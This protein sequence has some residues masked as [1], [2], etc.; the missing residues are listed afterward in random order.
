MKTRISIIVLAL[1]ALAAFAAPASA[2]GPRPRSGGGVS[3]GGNTTVE[4]GSSS[5]G[6][7]WFG[8]NVTVRSGGA[9]DGDSV[10]FGGN[11][12]VEPGGR[13]QGDIVLLGGKMD[14]AGEANGDLVLVG[15][16]VRLK[17]T[18]VVK[19]NIRLQGGNLQRDDG[20]IVQGDVNRN[21]GPFIPIPS[22]PPLP[23]GTVRSNFG[24]FDFFGGIIHAM[25]LA[26]LG[27]L[28]VVFFPSP[29]QRVSETVQHSFAPSF[30]VGCLTFVIAPVLLL[31]LTITIIGIPIVALLAIV[32]AAAWYLGWITLGYLAGERILQA[33]KVREIAPVLAAVVGVVLLAFVGAVPVLGGM[34]SLLI[35]TLGLGAVILTRFGTRSYP[36][37]PPLLPSPM[38]APPQTA[39]TDPP[40]SE[41][42]KPG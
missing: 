9:I 40:P 12:T 26:V 11:L 31:A 32:G 39:L 41:V 37:L 3:F 24:A 20:A 28:V 33:L 27:A 5:E 34:V 2:Q 21:S 1:W 38:S 25:A 13:V 6:G 22:R 42:N 7:V 23:F 8:G 16:N 14:L 10:L 18:A 15:G 17:P 36:L 35:G 30:G 19:G 29:I 4:S